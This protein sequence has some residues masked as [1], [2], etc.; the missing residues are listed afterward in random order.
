MNRLKQAAQQ[1]VDAWNDPLGMKRVCEAMDALHA[2]LEQDDK[3]R[4]WIEER[5]AAWVKDRELARANA[6]EESA[7]I[8]KAAEEGKCWACGALKQEP[9]D[10][11]AD[12]VC[13]ALDCCKDVPETD[14]GNMEPEQE[15]LTGC[16]SCGMDGGCD[17]EA[18]EQPEQEPVAWI[19]RDHLQKAQ[20]EPFLCRVEP[21]QRLPDF[22]PLYTHP[23]RRDV[24]QE[25]INDEYEVRADGKR[26]RKDRWQ[27]GI[28]R[29]VALLWGNRKGFEIDEVVEAVRA[30]VPQPFSDGDDEALVRAALEQPEQDVPETDCGNMEPVAIVSSVTEP[31]QYGVKVRWLGGFPQIAMKLYTHPPRREWRS[32]SDEEID[33]LIWHPNGKTLNTNVEYARAIEAALK[34]KNHE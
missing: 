24:E 11:A 3:D 32:L 18:L 28:R 7:R 22:V 10:I 9:C 20:R 34:E 25:P 14:C 30:L 4:V 26:V 1:V 33:A 31:G 5:K 27:V 12:G 19:Q 29:I 15:W 17:C 21:T 23:P 6:A 8:A 16:P 13:E 2:A